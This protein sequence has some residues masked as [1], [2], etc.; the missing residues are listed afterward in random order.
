M[1]INKKLYQFLFALITVI[2]FSAC[3]SKKAVTTDT[4]TYQPK[5]TQAAKIADALGSYTDWKQLRMS[6]KLHISSVPVTPSL[7]IYMKK[8]TDLT[9]SASAIFVGEVFRVELNSDSLFIVNKLKKVYCKESGEK[10]KEIYPTVCEEIQSLLLG[11]MVVPCAG[12]L[13]EKNIDKV[14]IEMENDMRKVIPDL[15]KMPLDVA[16]TYL[17]DNSGKIANLSVGNAG[18]SI[19]SIDYTWKGNG[20][21]EMLSEFRKNNKTTKIE[22]DLDSPQWDGGPLSPFKLGSGYKRVGL[23]DF[24]KSI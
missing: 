15:G 21:V 13:S 4:A 9:I 19:F 6:G 16:L 5:N 23:K 12:T 17:I 22:I 11:R 20:S 7:K 18:K 14:A 24:F 1:N 8:G 3:A 2:S 10:L